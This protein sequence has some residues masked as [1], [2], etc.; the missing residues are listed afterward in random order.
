MATGRSQ[1]R[2]FRRTRSSKSLSRR[3]S[4]I[5]CTLLLAP[6]GVDVEI[7]SDSVQTTPPAVSE[8]GGGSTSFKFGAGGGSY[9]RTIQA[10]RTISL[11]IN[12]CTGEPVTQTFSREFYFKDDYVDAGGEID[13]HVSNS[14][15]HLGVRGGFVSDRGSLRTQPT[16]A[17]EDSLFQNVRFDESQ[18]TIYFNPFVSLEGTYFGAGL[19]V[20]LPTNRLWRNG[21][22][23]YDDYQNADVLPS[24]HIRLGSLHTAYLNATL[25]EG[26]PIYSGGGEYTYGLGFRPAEPLALW[27][28]GAGGGPYTRDAL[29]LRANIDFSRHWTLGGAL[30]WP[31][32]AGNSY[33]PTFDEY[34]VGF[35][36]T[37]TNRRE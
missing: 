24:G 36:M 33:V 15:W 27:I 22:V 10:S 28:G 8:P 1:F 35:T 30:R 6:M 11:G 17:L 19:G 4:I 25:W 31:S 23:N 5:A 2:V 14:H 29:M 13:H 7:P 18:S 9:G 3:R 16:S 21:T 32:S 12:E 34:G 26:V 37:Y 20:V